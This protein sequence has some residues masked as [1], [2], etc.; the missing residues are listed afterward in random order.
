MEEQNLGAVDGLHGS[1][2]QAINK[3]PN[4]LKVAFLGLVDQPVRHASKTVRTLMKRNPQSFVERSLAI[5]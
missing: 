3:L 2:V 1:A 4:R 5:N